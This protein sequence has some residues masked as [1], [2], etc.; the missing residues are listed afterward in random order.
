MRSLSNGVLWVNCET[1]HKGELGERLFCVAL[2]KATLIKTH[3]FNQ[4]MNCVLR[5]Y[6]AGIMGADLE[7]PKDP[8]A[9]KDKQTVMRTT[10][11]DAL[12]NRW[13]MGATNIHLTMQRYYQ[14]VR[15]LDRN[16]RSYIDLSE[17]FFL[18]FLGGEKE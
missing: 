15:D 9:L 11:V 17:Q 12:Y 18:Y 10:E 5:Y 1:P 6:F 2:N 7:F 3:D 4:I 14:M 13:A 8:K 16:V